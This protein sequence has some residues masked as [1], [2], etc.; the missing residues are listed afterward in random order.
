[1]TQYRFDIW[2]PVCR[3]PYSGFKGKQIRGLAIVSPSSLVDA[4]SLNQQMGC[5]DC[6]ASFRLEF[7]RAE[8]GQLLVEVFND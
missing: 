8:T 4:Q 1:M 2:C 5:S 3:K 7:V 6:S